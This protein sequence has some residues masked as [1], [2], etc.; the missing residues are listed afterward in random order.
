M[1]REA[2]LNINNFEGNLQVHEG[3]SKYTFFK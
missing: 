2:P 1:S 3:E